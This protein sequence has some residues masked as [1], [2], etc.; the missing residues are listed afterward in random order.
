M[1]DHA[2]LVDIR[3]V[4]K[5][6]EGPQGPIHA[7]KR[8]N[9]RVGAGEFVGIRG[10]SG[11]GKSTLLN[12][13]T[14]VDRPTAGQVLVNGQDLTELNEDRLARWRGDT[15]G[16]VFQFF[17]LLPTLTVL[18]N[19]ILPMDFA[20]RGRPK[21]RLERAQM[22]LEQVGLADQAQKF[23][24]AL[25]GGQQQRA[26]IA[27]A[28][29]NDPPLLVGDE[30]TG[31]LDSKTAHGVVD[32]FEEL[33]ARGKTFLMVTHSNSLAARIPRVIEVLDGELFEN[34]ARSGK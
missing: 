17:Q 16:V 10:P 6:Y 23:P 22:L 12:M 24:N 29:A 34:G 19:V 21:E 3:D 2:A 20:R 18:E 7:L 1:S 9:L 32:T 27:R 4:V 26:A 8:V 11:S 25:S 13:I 5:D 30:P 15:V 31:N 14:G 28:L 33:V